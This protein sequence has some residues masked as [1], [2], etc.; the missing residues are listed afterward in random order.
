MGRDQLFHTGLSP[1]VSPGTPLNGACHAAGRRRS[2]E[3]RE[4]GGAS[5]HKGGSEEAG[6]QGLGR[7]CAEDT[8]AAESP[9]PCIAP[10][11]PGIRD[12]GRTGPGLIRITGLTLRFIIPLCRLS[13]WNTL[14]FLEATMWIRLRPGGG[15]TARGGLRSSRPAQMTEERSAPSLP[16]V[17]RFVR[18]HLQ[19][20]AVTLQ[21]GRGSDETM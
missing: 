13:F 11:K 9:S 4:T 7:T 10:P 21:R 16:R 15:L 1:A 6:E 20:P 8:N 12:P 14:Y 18:I 5:E 17:A 2:G 3:Q 19:S